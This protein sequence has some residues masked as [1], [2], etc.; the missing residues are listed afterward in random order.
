MFVSYLTCHLNASGHVRPV[1]AVR[2]AQ[3]QIF[4]FLEVAVTRCTC[5]MSACQTAPPCERNTVAHLHPASLPPSFLSTC[6]RGFLF[7]TL[8]PRLLGLMVLFQ[9]LLH[10][11]LCG[12]LSI[13]VPYSNKTGPPFSLFRSRPPTTLFVLHTPFVCLS[14]VPCTSHLCLSMSAGRHRHLV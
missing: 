4:L 9:L 5:C 1:A 2:F 6:R 10:R 3:A 11:P 12:F 14:L 13:D 7:R 8:R